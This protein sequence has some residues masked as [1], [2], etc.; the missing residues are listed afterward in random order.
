MHQYSIWIV[1]VVAVIAGLIGY[2]RSKDGKN[3]EA[4]RCVYCCGLFIL[5]WL[6]TVGGFPRT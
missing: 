5:L 3:S 4:W 6:L 2:F 1:P